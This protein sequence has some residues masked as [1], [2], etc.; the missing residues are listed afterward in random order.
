MRVLLVDDSPT[1]RNIIRVYLMKFRVEFV[2]ADT[3]ERA[4]QL[5]RLMSPQLI[6]ADVNMP[7]MGGIGLVRAV[8]E[9]GGALAATPIILLTGEQDPEIEQQGRAAGANDFIKKPVALDA[10]V[11]VVRKYIQE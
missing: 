3:G 11:S 4:A 6:I 5:A 10:L 8:R 2:E 1:V 7:G 9:A